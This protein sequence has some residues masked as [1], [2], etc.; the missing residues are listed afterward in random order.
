MTMQYEINAYPGFTSNGFDYLF[1][2]IYYRMPPFLLGIGLAI[3][4]FE[5]KFVGTL[6]DGSKPFHKPII[7]H[8]RKNKLHKLISY[9]IGLSLCIFSVL[10]MLTNTNCVDKSPAPD[11]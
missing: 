4:K 8:F 1:M 5:Y 9:F 6:N 2:K 7:D 11:N 10:I 3:I